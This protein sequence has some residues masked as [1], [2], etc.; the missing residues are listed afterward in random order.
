MDE[1]TPGLYTTLQ[2]TIQVAHRAHLARIMR[3]LRLIPE[4]VR[5]ARVRG[6]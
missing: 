2:F 3:S 6:E 4:V 1:K 5:I